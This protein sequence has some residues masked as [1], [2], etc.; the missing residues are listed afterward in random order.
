M[1]SLQNVGDAENVCSGQNGAEASDVCF[2]LRLAPLHPSR[3]RNLTENR[4]TTPPL[5][6]TSRA[7]HTPRTP[8][9]PQRKP[10]VNNWT[11]NASAIEKKIIS[12]GVSRNV[13]GV[14]DK[15][16]VADAE[17][18][19]LVGIENRVVPDVTAVSDSD[20]N[21]ESSSTYTDPIL[22]KCSDSHDE[23]I[24]HL[25]SVIQRARAAMNNEI[26]YSDD[27]RTSNHNKSVRT[28]KTL[29]P[30]PCIA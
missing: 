28:W 25:D 27:D 4:R 19:I 15:R 12:R 2:D 1:T 26:Y 5:E 13:A 18:R 6:R 23:I 9:T 16:R 20:S 11:E 14:M 7:S 30:L 22:H 29:P 10:M 21:T 24:R 17:S 3:S 8:R